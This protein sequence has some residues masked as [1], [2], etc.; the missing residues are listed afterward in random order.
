[1]ITDPNLDNLPEP[2]RERRGHD[3][4]PPAAELATIPAL[5]ETDDA[6]PLGDRVVH[7]H[8]FVGGCDWWLIEVDVPEGR[9]FGYVRLGSDHG[10]EW[11]YVDLHDLARI[12]VTRVNFPVERDLHWRPRSAREVLPATAW[13]WN[14]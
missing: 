2:H 9:G 8:Y 11:G 7:L 10:A 6:G 12:L 13:A 4:W 5:Y 14:D 3:F 1:M